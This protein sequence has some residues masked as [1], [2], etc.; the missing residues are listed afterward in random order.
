[1]IIG[2]EDADDHIPGAGI[3]GTA[4]AYWPHRH[5][6]EPTVVERAGGIREGDYKV[7][8]RGAALDVVTRMGLREQIRAQRTAVRTGSIVDAAGKRVAAID[9]DTFGGRQAQ[10]AGLAGY[11][12]ELRPFVAV[13]QKLGSANIKRMVLR[14]AGQVRMSMTMLRLINRLPGK[15][16]LMAKT[17]EPIHKAAAAIVLKEY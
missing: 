6:F 9:G 1:M 3:A 11:E 10:D 5:G 13:N 4:A 7:D 12:R 17:M 8:I 16:R 15:D 14:S 2:C